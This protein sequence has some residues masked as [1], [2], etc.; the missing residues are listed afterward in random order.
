MITITQNADDV[1]LRDAPTL[2]DVAAIYGQSVAIGW[3]YTL[4]VN[5]SEF[6]GLR[7][8]VSEQQGYELAELVLC[9]FFYLKMTE[10]LLFCRRFKAGRYLRF[11]ASFDPQSFMASIRMFLA[12]RNEAYAKYY[13]NNEK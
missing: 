10:M 13:Q 11:Y 12:D 7:D 4:I 9:E 3:L 1:F 8:R 6:C 2:I 5:I